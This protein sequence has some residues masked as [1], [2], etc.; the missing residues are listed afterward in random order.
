MVGKTISRFV[1]KVAGPAADEVGLMLQD[2]VKVYRLKN[3]LRLMK[4]AEEILEKSGKDPKTVPYRTLLPILEK[5]SLEDDDLL[6]DKWAALLANAADA[7]RNSAVTPSYPNILEQISPV[8]AQILD[9]LYSSLKDNDFREAQ[10]LIDI[11]DFAELDQEKTKVLIDNLSRLG[12][13]VSGGA[14]GENSFTLE[15]RGY[16]VVGLTPLGQAFI[17]ACQEQVNE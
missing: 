4:K 9:Y 17:P 8:E 5:G 10:H 11:C 12:L 1:E 6:N 2:S 3:Q 14:F 15:I 13:V 7:V 16:D